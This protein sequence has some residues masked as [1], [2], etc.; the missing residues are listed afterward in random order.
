MTSSSHGSFRAIDFCYLFARSSLSGS[1]RICNRQLLA[2]Q[3]IVQMTVRPD[4]RSSGLL[5]YC[6]IFHLM[7]YNYTSENVISFQRAGACQLT[8]KVDT[9]SS[10]ECC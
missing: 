7:F 9:V 6:I 5:S 10:S 8:G 2:S 1:V 4:K 3:V